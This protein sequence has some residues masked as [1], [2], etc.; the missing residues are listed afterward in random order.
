MKTTSSRIAPVAPAQATGRIRELYEGAQAKFGFVSN[1]LQ[2]FGASPAALEGY[3]GFNG[4]LANGTF[5][6]A[7]RE[8]IALAVAEANL[9]GYCLSIHAFIG[10]QVGLTPKEISA[11]R[12]ATAADGRGDAILKLARSIIVLR[13]E[14]RD[15]D[16]R[17]ARASSLSDGEIVETV[18]N[19]ALNTLLNYM[20]H[21]ALPK[22][23]FPEVKPGVGYDD[24]VPA[25]RTRRKR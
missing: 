15:S 14:I 7:L 3:I 5:S 16:I 8:Q 22:V 6:P 10:T 17:E 23:D 18:A 1:L 25:S 21:V 9:C 12:R 2:V 20:N 24:V 11:A 13:G 4:A 19:V